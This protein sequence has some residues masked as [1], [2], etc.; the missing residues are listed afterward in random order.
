LSPLL[1]EDPTSS[2]IGDGAVRVEAQARPQPG[3][4]DPARSWA[5]RT[6]WRSWA[7]TTRRRSQGGRC[8]L[9]TAATDPGKNWRGQCDLTTAV[10]DLRMDGERTPRPYRIWSRRKR[11]WPDGGD[12]GADAGEPALVADMS[13]ERLS[14]LI[15][16]SKILSVWCIAHANSSAN[17]NEH[18]LLL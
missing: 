5:T 11:S 17:L 7:T 2:R 1:G 8:D 10:A 15:N 16:S 4:S 12:Q 13:R 6:R 18:I 9:L 3:R 14:C